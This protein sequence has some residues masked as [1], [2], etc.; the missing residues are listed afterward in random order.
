MDVRFCLV[1]PGKS[2][3]RRIVVFNTKLN[4]GNAK[5]D[6]NCLKEEISQLTSL[7]KN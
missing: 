4:I 6:M 5:E 1:Q 7:R 2:R 3:N